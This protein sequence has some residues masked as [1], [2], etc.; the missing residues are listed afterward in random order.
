MSHKKHFIVYTKALKQN[1]RDIYN[2][3]H[4]PSI[5]FQSKKQKQTFDCAIYSCEHILD[6][7]TL[8]VNPPT[9]VNTQYNDLK[10]LQME[11]KW[12]LHDTALSRIDPSFITIP[13]IR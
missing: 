2:S 5:I 4:N 9:F 6:I 7:V 8:G 12:T 11:H 13:K 10:L 1:W 3:A